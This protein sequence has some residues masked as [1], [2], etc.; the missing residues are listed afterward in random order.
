MTMSELVKTPLIELCEALDEALRL[1]PKG[2]SIPGLLETYASTQTDWEPFKN[3]VEGRYTRSL[4][5]R[6][7]DYE[8]LLLSWGAGEESPIHNHMGQR[9]WMAVVEGEVEEVH[10]NRAAGG[11][12]PLIE[13]PTKCFP[14]GKVAFINDEIALHMVRGAAG[15]AAV[16]LHLYSKP[17]DI[18]LIYDPLTGAE[19][20]RT[21]SYDRTD[22]ALEGPLVT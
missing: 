2:A 18:C 1:D 13:G 7:E 4:V 5:R 15:K 22:G 14:A 12:G 9:C 17:Y 11:P 10:F 3:F 19:S 20:A 21:L 6:T 16:S 8:L